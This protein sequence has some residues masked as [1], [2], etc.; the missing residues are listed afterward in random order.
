MQTVKNI[1]TNKGKIDKK[2]YENRCC[3]KHYLDLIAKNVK[4]ELLYVYKEPET[5]YSALD[6][7]G[8]GKISLQTFLKNVIVKRLNIPEEDLKQ[9]LI[10]DK[11]FPDESSQIDFALL[12]KKFFPHLVLIEEVNEMDLN[13][14]DKQ[15]QILFDKQGNNQT[16]KDQGKE[17]VL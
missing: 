9:W 3:K 2:L 14:T 10:R 12:K 7:V 8:T 5:A 1:N 6:F 17:M 15:H 16:T 13:D 4:K 11:I